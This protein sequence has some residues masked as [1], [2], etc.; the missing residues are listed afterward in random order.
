MEGGANVLMSADHYVRLEEEGRGSGVADSPSSLRCFWV[1][2]QASQFSPQ[3]L[4]LGF[5]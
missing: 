1:S 5:G 2:P 3:L 4:H